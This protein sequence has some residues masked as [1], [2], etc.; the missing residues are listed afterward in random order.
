MKK[1]ILIIILFSPFCKSFAQQNGVQFTLR[2]NTTNNRY[3]VYA[4]PNFS[5]NNFTWG[6]SQIG[7]VLP[8]ST[9]NQVINITSISAGSWV[10]KSRV[11]APLADTAHDYHGLV[12][13]GDLI[14]L[15]NG[16]ESLLFT[17]TLPDGQCRNGVRLFVNG[18]DPASSAAGMAGGDFKNSIFSGVEIY[19]GNYNNIGS[20][21][22]TC[23]IVA[24]EL[25]K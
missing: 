20:Q 15:T 23:N 9:P 1:I 14:N 16:V 7:L 8:E 22:N 25:I 10:D 3:E 18:S 12:S 4:K 24:P 17:F 19:G 21:C 2:W 13:D 6:P 11:F 5:A